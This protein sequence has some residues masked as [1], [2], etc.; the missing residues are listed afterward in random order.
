[1][2]NAVTYEQ[3]QKK[4]VIDLDSLICEREWREPNSYFTPS[5]LAISLGSACLLTMMFMVL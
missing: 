2:H 3:K 5:F 1:M 4:R